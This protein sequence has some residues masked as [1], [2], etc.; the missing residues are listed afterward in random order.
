MDQDAIFK[1]F[2]VSK[3]LNKWN[4]FEY[5]DPNALFT[6]E[7][8]IYKH[9]EHLQGDVIPKFLG[10]GSLYGLLKVII[11]QD[12]GRSITKEEFMER[13][14]EWSALLDKIHD[15]GVKHGDV[16]YPNITL[17]NQNKMRIIDFGFSTI[18]AGPITE[19]IDFDT[20]TMEMT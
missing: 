11:L 20:R 12:V 17:D 7:V 5:V 19:E 8:E 9:L 1:T 3:P 4:I 16:R 10:C 18:E 15:S 6:H 13:K 2:D 14:D